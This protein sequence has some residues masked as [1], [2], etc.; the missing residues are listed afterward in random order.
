M[1]VWCFNCVVLFG[2]IAC[3]WLFVDFVVITLLT[4]CCWYL[5]VYG[6]FLG[7]FGLMFVGVVW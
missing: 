5:V 3:G 4:L 6:S 7:V 1:A 2:L